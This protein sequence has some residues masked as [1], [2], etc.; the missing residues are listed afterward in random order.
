MLAAVPS[1]SATRCLQEQPCTAVGQPVRVHEIPGA[2]LARVEDPQHNVSDHA[3]TEC[4][5][6]MTRARGLKL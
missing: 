3:G 1:V 2:T 5:K 4:A 6:L